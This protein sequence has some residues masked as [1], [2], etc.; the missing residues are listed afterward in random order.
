MTTNEVVNLDL[1]IRQLMVKKEYRTR[2][3]RESLWTYCRLID[4]RKFYVKERWHLRLYTEV[5]QLLHERRLN[6]A[7]FIKAA[8]AY[9]PPWFTVTKAYEEILEQLDDREYYDALMINL[10]PRIGKTRT[11]T[12]ATSWY[13]GRDKRESIITAA[14]NDDLAQDFS[15]STRNK[16]G[17]EKTSPFDVTHQDV[18]PDSKLQWGSKSASKWNIEGGYQSYTGVGLNGSATGKGGSTILV[19]DPIK[20]SKI[21]YNKRA[22]DEINSWFRN[23]L[24]SRKEKGALTIINHTRWSVDDLCGHMLSLENGKDW[25]VFKLPAYFADVDEYLDPTEYD[26]KRYNDIRMVLNADIFS[27][28]YNQKTVDLKGK[29]YTDLQT[30]KDVPRDSKGNPLFERIVSYTDTADTG[31]DFLTMIIAG[32]YQGRAYV[33]DVLHTDAAMTETEIA[34]ADMLVFHQV[35][36]AKFEGNNGGSGHARSIEK[37]MFERHKSRKVQV[38]WFHQSEN[39]TARILSNQTNVQN[40]VLFPDDWERR[41]PSY[42]KAMTTYQRKGKNEH[43]DAPDATTGLVEHFLESKGLFIGLA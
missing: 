9:V 41:W 27:A 19:D 5:L 4:D 39:K 34:Q 2:K 22:L 29:L 14:Y 13:L 21:A 42:Y 32:I 10:P 30:Y 20:D 43:D 15:K 12:N 37:L 24:Y 6:K 35:N 18:F 36:M 7:N 8:E 31:A 26:K 38:E 16:I 40:N 28:N 25:F 23:T 3:A 17:A 11:L 33:L 1:A